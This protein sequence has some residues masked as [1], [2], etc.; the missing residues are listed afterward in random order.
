M[1][2]GFPVALR[3]LVDKT[4]NV[5]RTREDAARVVSLRAN[6]VSSAATG[7]TGAQ[8]CLLCV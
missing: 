6:E 4:E 1:F 3:G 2:A 5:P 7:L 8:I